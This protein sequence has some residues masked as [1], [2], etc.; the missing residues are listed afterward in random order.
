MEENKYRIGSH[1]Y[2]LNTPKS[3][4]DDMTIY[5]DDRDYLRIFKQ[6]PDVSETNGNNT[7]LYSLAYYAELLAKGNPNLVELVNLRPYEENSPVVSDFMT[8]LRN[9][10]DTLVHRRVLEA[11]NGHLI[12]IEKEV[13]VK[14]VSPK[15]L[16]HALRICYSLKYAVQTGNLLILK[17]HEDLRQNC[18]HIKQLEDVTDYDIYMV[19]YEINEARTSF[20]NKVDE[21]PDNTKLKELINT[22][23]EE[24]Y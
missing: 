19:N 9:N 14:G 3:D 2:G 12:G 20:K 11:Y 24:L 7:K 1:M 21:F 17:D 15:R 6:H 5:F 18:L 8:M 23:M 4:E 16:S 10:M 22:F 13:K